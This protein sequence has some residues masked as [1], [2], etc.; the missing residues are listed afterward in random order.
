MRLGY[1][2]YHIYTENHNAYPTFLLRERLSKARQFVKIKISVEGKM[3]KNEYGK[4]KLKKQKKEKNGKEKL[5]QYYLHCK[6]Y[7]K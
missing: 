5:S 2:L 6:T 3:T 1:T 7:L 4:G